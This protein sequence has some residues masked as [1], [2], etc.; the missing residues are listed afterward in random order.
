MR[1][2][3]FSV[4]EWILWVGSMLC[5]II[6][7]LLFDGGRILSLMASLIG[8]T[9]LIFCAK[10]H[11]IGQL[12]M[13][14][15]SAL[16]GILSYSCAYYGE[17]ITYLGMTAPM[18]ALSLISWITHPFKGKKSEVAVARLSRP[19]AIWLL[20]LTV[21]VTAAGYVLLRALGTAALIPA[22]ISIATSFAA[23]YLTFF[24]SAYFA[25]VYAL[26]DLVLIVLWALASAEDR[27][28]LPLLICFLVFFVNDSYGFLCWKRSWRRQNT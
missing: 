4:G 14:I 27:S 25:L 9:S 19:A 6:S 20:P 5:L 11:P 3:Y 2:R 22:T 8:V 10:G 18:A 1:W 24:R 15:F 28:Y 16:Y 23:A 12:L 21:A 26:N 13:L 7:F 17:M